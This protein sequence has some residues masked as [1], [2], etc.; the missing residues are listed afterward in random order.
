MPEYLLHKFD[1]SG[2]MKNKTK[3]EMYD[4]LKAYLIDKQEPVTNL[5]EFDKVAPNSTPAD[6]MRLLV[7]TV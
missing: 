6:V 5:I 4:A 2:N 7:D 3:Q 1:S